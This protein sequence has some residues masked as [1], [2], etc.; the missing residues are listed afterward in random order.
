MATKEECLTVEE[1]MAQLQVSKTKL[2]NDIN[3]LGIQKIRFPFDRRTYI[4]KT[5]VERIK[6]YRDR[7]RNGNGIRHQD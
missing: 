1:A 2:Y 5:E 4:L 6:T 3:Y 7:I